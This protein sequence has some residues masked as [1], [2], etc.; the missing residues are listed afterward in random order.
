MESFSFGDSPEMADE[1]LALVLSGRK[2]ATSWAASL[3]PQGDEVGKRS[4]IKDG[5]GRPR[6]VIETIELTRRRFSEVDES[7]A[8]DEGEGD[9]SLEY[10]RKEHQRYFTQEGTFSEDMEVYCARFRSIEVLRT[11]E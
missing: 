4:V 6:A 7:F 8:H 1:L 2:K 5:K 3:G 9:L 10:W 11:D